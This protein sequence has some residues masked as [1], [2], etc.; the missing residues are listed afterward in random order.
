MTKPQR[1]PH[2]EVA[3]VPM[4]TTAGQMIFSWSCIT[5]WPD[6]TRHKFVVAAGKY[7]KGDPDWRHWYRH[8]WRIVKVSIT[9]QMPKRRAKR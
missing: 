3:Y 2:R 7:T 8:G 9:E 1:K 4:R 6:S 5:P